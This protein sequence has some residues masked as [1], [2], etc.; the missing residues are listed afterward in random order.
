MRFFDGLVLV[1]FR[2]DQRKGALCPGGPG[3]F[4]TETPRAGD[5]GN[6]AVLCL[7]IYSF[8]RCTLSHGAV[9]KIEFGTI[10]YVID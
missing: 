1:L 4:R 10:I 7:Y 5:L 6:C 9:R 2:G 3:P 8:W